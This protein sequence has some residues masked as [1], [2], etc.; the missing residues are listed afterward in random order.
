MKKLGV[1]MRAGRK[2]IMT[3]EVVK[4]LEEA[5]LLGC[6][7]LEACFYANISKQTLYTYQ[8]KNPEFVDRKEQL[9]ENPIFIARKSVI[10]GLSNPDLA[11]KFLERKKKDEFSTKI[12]SAT[13]ITFTQMGVV[14]KEDKGQIKE[15]SFKLK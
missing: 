1:I 8:D 14:K 4:K 6:S 5:F 12:E 7:D 2:T 11:L 15:I 3:L 13:D 9:K 10:T